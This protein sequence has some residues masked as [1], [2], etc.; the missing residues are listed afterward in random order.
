MILGVDVGNYYTKTSEGISF[1]S[2]VSEKKN[3]LKNEEIRIGDNIMYLGEGEFDTEYRKAYKTNYL[4]L[5]KGAIKKST[6]EVRNNKIIVGLPISQYK[7]DKDY[8]KN[9]ILES[10]IASDVEVV[11]EGVLTIRKTGILVDIGGRTTD[12]CL[13]YEEGMVNKIIQPYSLPIGM[14]NVEG[15]LIESINNMYGLD[16]T[17]EDHDRILK[18]GLRINGEEKE[19]SLFAYKNYVE[20]I[21]NRIQINYSIKTND[22]FLVGG[23][24]KRLYNSFKKRLPQVRLIE[25][26]FFANA[27]AFYNY[28]RGKWNV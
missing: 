4:Y 27:I 11:P 22:I 15:E 3:I 14:L 20:K 7:T 10:G 21:V 23:G 24:A 19:F 28:G 9:R 17:L 26:A 5:L 13:I 16:L 2:K 25:N 18:Y 6:R 12:I 1:L 8:L